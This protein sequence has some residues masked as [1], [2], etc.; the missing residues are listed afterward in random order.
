MEGAHAGSQQTPERP[1]QVS[2][3]VDTYQYR[4]YKLFIVKFQANCCFNF[5]FQKK[6]H[7]GLSSQFVM[8]EIL[9]F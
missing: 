6:I 5:A 7:W 2:S 4:Y 8:L 1:E 3:V 9:S